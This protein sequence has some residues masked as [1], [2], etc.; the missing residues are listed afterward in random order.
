MQAA[1]SLTPILASQ[2]SQTCG[3][4]GASQRR[5][6]RRL[7]IALGSAVMLGLTILG[8]DQN[9]LTVAMGVT[10]AAHSAR[11]STGEASKQQL[12]SVYLRVL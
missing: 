12:A 8:L 3:M 11:R 4:P 10:S 7:V 1:N 2:Q 9:W 5:F 6:R